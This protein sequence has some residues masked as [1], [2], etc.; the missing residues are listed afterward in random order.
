MFSGS[1]NVSI[2]KIPTCQNLFYC[3]IE[4]LPPKLQSGSESGSEYLQCNI[5]KGK[6]QG[7]KEPNEILLMP[8]K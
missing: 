8:S 2:K 1:L 4:E 7:K 3:A 6:Y 5:L